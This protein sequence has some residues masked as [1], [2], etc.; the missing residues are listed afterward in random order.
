NNYEIDKATR[1]IADFIDDLSTWY[2]RRSRDRFK[3][4]SNPNDLIARSTEGGFREDIGNDRDFAIATTKYV[5]EILSKILAPFMP[6]IAEEIWQN[7]TENNF[8]N[9]DRSVHLEEWPIFKD[10]ID[11]NLLVEMKVVRDVI[12]LGLEIRA[13]EGIKVRQ[14]LRELKVKSSKLKGREDLLELVKDELNVKEINFDKNIE[15][16]VKFDLEITLELKQE[17][18]FREF[19]RNIQRLRK[20]KGL[21][22]S[23]MINISIET[24]EKGKIL[25]EKFSSELKRIAGIKEIQFIEVKDDPKPVVRQG[26]EIIIE[27]YYFIINII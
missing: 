15:N 22:P 7:V 4:K 19:L 2:L 27:D 10:K 23:D 11:E 6:F 25:I 8:E 20:E 26:Q 21:V 12:S 1:P 14:P 16:E 17:G 24:D 18:D 3:A 9:E 13:K 5:L